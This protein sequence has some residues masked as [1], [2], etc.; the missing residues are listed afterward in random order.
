MNYGEWKELGLPMNWCIHSE[1]YEDRDDD[2]N[3]WELDL[4]APVEDGIYDLTLRPSVKDPKNTYPQFNTDEHIQKYNDA[5]PRIGGV[6]VKDGKFEP[7]STAYAAYVVERMFY[8]Q[9][10]GW[11]KHKPFGEMMEHCY[12]ESLEWDKKE[13]CFYLGVG[14]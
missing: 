12:I 14:S 4:S 1:K 7:F 3:N 11:Y 9:W 13:N 10:T 6:V 5:I 2:P 8:E